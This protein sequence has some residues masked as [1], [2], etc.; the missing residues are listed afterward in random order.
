MILFP[1]M[2]AWMWLEI[3]RASPLLAFVPLRREH[4]QTEISWVSVPLEGG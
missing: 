3:F 1:L 2:T 4:R